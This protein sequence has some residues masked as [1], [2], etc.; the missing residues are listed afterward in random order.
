MAFE[1]V[2]LTAKGAKDCAK[3]AKGNLIFCAL[4]D[5]CVKRHQLILDS[6]LT[7]PCVVLTFGLL[8]DLCG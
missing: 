6:S 4:C 3:D 2:I 7:T 1:K 8:C 5:L